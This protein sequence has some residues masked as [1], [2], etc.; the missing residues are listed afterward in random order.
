MLSAKVSRLPSDSLHSASWMSATGASDGCRVAC[1]AFVWW[2][3]RRYFVVW[4]AVKFA[5]ICQRFGWGA[6]LAPCEAREK[7]G[8][9]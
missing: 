7:G 8:E 9:A 3:P 2:R 4:D 5:R 6:F 1:A